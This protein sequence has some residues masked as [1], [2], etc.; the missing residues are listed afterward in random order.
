MKD[1]IKVTTVGTQYDEEHVVCIT[2]DARDLL[3]NFLH[4]EIEE[5]QD[6]LRHRG[7]VFP[8][9]WPLKVYRAKGKIKIVNALV[10]QLDDME[11][12]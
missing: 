7:E 11:T 6:T 8:S 3:L 5:L 4:A 12:C 9:K 2:E 10:A 1:Q